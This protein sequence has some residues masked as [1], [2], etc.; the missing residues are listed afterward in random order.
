MRESCPRGPR[1]QALRRAVP[2]RLPAWRNVCS[3][4]VFQGKGRDG[5]GES[6]GSRVRAHFDSLHLGA[7]PC[8]EQH[9]FRHASRRRDDWESSLPVIS[10]LVPGAAT[11]SAKASSE[12]SPGSS[13]MLRSLPT[14]TPAFRPLRGPAPESP[15]AHP[16]QPAGIASRDDASAQ[17]DVSTLGGVDHVLSGETVKD[18]R[19]IRLLT[20][21]AER[22]RV[23]VG[24]ALVVLSKRITS[25]P[26]W[27]FTQPRMSSQYLMR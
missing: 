23:D 14:A 2:L 21:R 11:S 19:D 17:H 20:I 16:A 18:G 4:R 8:A 24:H 12:S 3:Q 10:S 13:M 9:V 5:G 7:G 27:S 26:C 6:C 1:D 15:P 22:R 25:G